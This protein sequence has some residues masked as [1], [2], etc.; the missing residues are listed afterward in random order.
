MHAHTRK[1]D[2]VDRLHSLGISIS[3]DR[4]LRLSAQ[5]GSNVCEQFHWEHVVCPPKLK[6]KVFTALYGGNLRILIRTVDTDV[7]LLA[8]SLAS[9]LGPDLKSG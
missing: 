7:I 9:I 3:Y 5:L 2:L 8:V 4:V 1:R 6:H